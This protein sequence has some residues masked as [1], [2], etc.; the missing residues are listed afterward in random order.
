MCDESLSDFVWIHFWIREGN[1]RAPSTF[2]KRKKRILCFSHLPLVLL[3]SF[4][5][6]RFRF[7][8]RLHIVLLFFDFWFSKFYVE[9]RFLF[10][11]ICH[12]PLHVP[13]Y[14]IEMM[15]DFD[16]FFVH[17][18]G[19]AKLNNGTGNACNWLTYPYAFWPII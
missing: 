12:G 18:S 15:G 19:H 9:H 11:C 16:L 6:S 2:L 7:Q 3:P 14:C 8:Q 10:L 1:A 4:S 17:S 5:F 13:S